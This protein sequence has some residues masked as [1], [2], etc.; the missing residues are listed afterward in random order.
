MILLAQSKNCFSWEE[1]QTFESTKEMYEMII[2][3]LVLALGFALVWLLLQKLKISKLRFETET[4]TFYVK[5]NEEKSI[6]K[7]FPI[8]PGTRFQFRWDSSLFEKRI[9]IGKT[10]GQIL[11]YAEC[12]EDYHIT[13]ILR[14][15][16]ER[17]GF[18]FLWEKEAEVVYFG[19]NGIFST[20]DIHPIF[21]LW[22]ERQNFSKATETAQAFSKKNPLLFRLGRDLEKTNHPKEYLEWECFFTEERSEASDEKL[23]LN[24]RL[25]SVM[26]GYDTARISELGIYTMLKF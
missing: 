19:P 3:G 2:I 11:T 13:F 17:N 8:L 16:L 7:T 24:I 15:D 6:K 23:L 10:E 4:K 5:A 20:K 9:S 25:R 22:D 12:I 21:F 14:N 26:P 18:L 1:I